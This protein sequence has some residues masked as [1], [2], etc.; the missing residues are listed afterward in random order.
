MPK[1]RDKRK[2]KKQAKKLMNAMYESAKDHV[3]TFREKDAL[4]AEEFLN[5]IRASDTGTDERVQIPIV[6]T[7]TLNVILPDETV[8]FNKNRVEKDHAK[9]SK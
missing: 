4:A 2:K 8:S 7:P 3:K 5:K 9:V 6:E 1:S